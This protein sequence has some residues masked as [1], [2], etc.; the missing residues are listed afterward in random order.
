MTNSERLCSS[1]KLEWRE[2]SDWSLSLVLLFLT[3]G[4]FVLSTLSRSLRCMSDN[5]TISS[6]AYLCANSR[7]I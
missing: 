6:G 2:H 3:V 4:K 1:V 7:R 5:L